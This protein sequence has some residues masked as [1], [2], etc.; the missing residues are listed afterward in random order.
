MSQLA[1]F[2]GSAMTKLGS[3]LTVLVVFALVFAVVGCGR[4]GVAATPQVQKAQESALQT[5]LDL[6]KAAVDAY[7]AMSGRVPTE[8]GKLPSPGGY[9]PVDFGANLT[10]DGK[11]WTFYPDLIIKLPRHHDEGVWRI[12]SNMRVSVDMSPDEY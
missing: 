8:D 5:D 11:R 2:P 4:G 10:L 12:E 1:G 7:F 6:V 3:G 9:S